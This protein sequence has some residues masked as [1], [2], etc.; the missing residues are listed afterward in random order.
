MQASTQS[1]LVKF[2]RL[3]A[4][5]MLLFFVLCV[6]AVYAGMGERRNL[7]TLA[8]IGTVIVFVFQL[9]Q[10]VSAIIVRRWWQVA[11]NVVGI[12][13]SLFAMICS[14]VALAAG[15]Y[16][17]PVIYDDTADSTEAAADS[18]YFYQEGEQ[19]KCRIVT[20]IP[21]AA[22]SH[23]VGEWLD[24][25]LGGCYAGDMSDIKEMVAF[26]G[27]YHIDSLQRMKDDGVPDY[28]ELSYDVRMDK[29]Y[30]TDKV[31]TY[32]L[33][34]Y[35]DF[36]GAHPS[37]QEFGATFRKSDGQRLTWDIVR[38]D[39]K[40]QLHD[41]VR[42]ML[43]GYMNVKTDEELMDILQ[44]ADD[45]SFIPLPVTPPYMTEEGFVLI[46]QQYEIAPYAYG[47]PGDTISY[48]QFKPYLT[49]WAKELISD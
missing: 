13:I 32:S 37:T 8:I 30:E 33:T 11:G 20:D 41:V 3:W 16:R 43:K 27:K 34:L 12:A 23:A 46:Y 15:Q 2:C 39:R 48:A 18:A 49:E 10:L 7:M 5:T 36:G 6:V 19:Q 40:Y 9:A 14:I 24:G 29:A 25:N 28:A 44:G 17:P 45:V 38:N 22:V 42:K 26:Y 35:Q 4:V 47:M 1:K 31:V 21:E